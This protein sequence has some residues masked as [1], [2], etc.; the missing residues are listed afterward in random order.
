MTNFIKRFKQRRQLIRRIIKIKMRNFKYTILPKEEDQYQC[1]VEIYMD[2]K[3]IYHKED[4]ISYL[5]YANYQYISII[6]IGR[7]VQISFQFDMV[8]HDTQGIIDMTNNV[9]KDF[10][11]VLGVLSNEKKILKHYPS[12]IKN[13]KNQ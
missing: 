1:L 11:Y 6:P 4:L 12:I 5:R 13:V 8:A 3:Y 10:K 9:K 7:F 2:L